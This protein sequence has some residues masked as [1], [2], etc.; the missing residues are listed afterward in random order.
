MDY[1]L[2]LPHT[3]TPPALGI[4]NKRERERV[5]MRESSF[6]PHQYMGFSIFGGGKEPFLINT[7]EPGWIADVPHLQITEAGKRERWVSNSSRWH[8]NTWRGRGC[9]TK[10]TLECSCCQWKSGRII[11]RILVIDEE[12]QSF[13]PSTPTNPPLSHLVSDANSTFSLS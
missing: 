13:L 6:W 7:H 3:A 1:S 2:R 4:Y 11:P 12:N 5:Y 9:V 8:R 10:R